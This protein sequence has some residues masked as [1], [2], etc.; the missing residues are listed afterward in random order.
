MAQPTPPRQEGSF[1]HASK[2]QTPPKETCDPTL[3]PDAVVRH[4]LPPLDTRSEEHTSELHS[5]RHLVCRLL[6]EKKKKNNTLPITRKHIDNSKGIAHK[7]KN[8]NKEIE[9]ELND[10]M[11]SSMNVAKL[12]Q[13]H[14][15]I[16]RSKQ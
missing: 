9:A 7:R 15:T 1:L 11:S 5:L 3:A 16:H 12:C 13:E 10:T 14:I 4:P 2:S 8:Q 6:L